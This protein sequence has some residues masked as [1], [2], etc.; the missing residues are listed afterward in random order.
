MTALAQCHGMMSSTQDCH[1]FF[2]LSFLSVSF[3][4]N[5]HLR[6]RRSRQELSHTYLI[7]AC[8]L[9]A[10]FLIH[11]SS[12]NPLKNQIAKQN[13][14]STAKKQSVVSRYP[15][16]HPP[17]SFSLARVFSTPS[18][19]FLSLWRRRARDLPSRRRGREPD[20]WAWGERND[21]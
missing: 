1:S 18:R 20:D 14:N 5:S 3:C 10:L 7:L 12:S 6:Q 9:Q 13:K 21:F 11:P 15:S 19:T 4:A 17:E 2:L 8:I 16:V